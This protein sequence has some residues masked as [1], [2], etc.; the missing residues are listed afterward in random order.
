[1]S[2]FGAIVSAIR[3]MEDHGL[4]AS[5]IDLEGNLLQI[6]MRKI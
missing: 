4:M 3:D 1:M 6:F 5:V 2:V